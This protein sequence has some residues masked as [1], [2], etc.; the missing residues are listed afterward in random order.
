MRRLLAGL[1]LSLL[2]AGGAQAAAP[3]PAQIGD[4][5]RYS[6][7]DDQIVTGDNATRLSIRSTFDIEVIDARAD[8]L[9]LRFTYRDLKLDSDRDVSGIS[10]GYIGV[11]IDVETGPAF[12]PLRLV[13]WPKVRE[14]ILAGSAPDSRR[15]LEPFFASLATDPQK[16]AENL[17]GELR[18][19]AQFQSFDAPAAGC[20]TR[21]DRQDS[22]VSIGLRYKSTSSA[23]VSGDDGWVLEADEH[24]LQTFDTGGTQ[25]TTIHVRR[26]S[27]QPTC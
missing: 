2:L 13:D 3:R 20:R 16:L 24:R 7:E 17:T 23:T 18:L 9:T 5:Y 27:P 4:V 21:S 6:A 11:P 25:D 26:L 15:A 22:G 8:G 10:D 19:L 1:A 14:A 12:Q